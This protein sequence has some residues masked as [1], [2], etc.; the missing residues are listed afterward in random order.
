MPASIAAGSQ[1]DAVAG[2]AAARIAR[3]VADLVT[4]GSIDLTAKAAGQAHLIAALLPSGT[5]VYVNHLRRQTLADTAAACASLHEAGLEPVPHLAARRVVSR[6]EL[7]AF[8]VDIVGR[9]GVQKVLLVGGDERQAQGPY[10][11]ST[12][13]LRDGILAACGI[14]E[15]GFAGYPE[16]HPDIAQRVL[17]DATSERIEIAGSQELG[18]HIVTQ[19]SLAPTRVVEYCAALSRRVTG[20]PNYA[21]VAG[22]TDP[23]ALL[24]YAQLC[25]VSSSLRALRAQG[26]NA[27]G[28]VTHPDPGEQLAA[29]AHYCDAHDW[30]NVVGAHVYSFGGVKRTAAWMNEM[31]AVQTATR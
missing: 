12:H 30:C 1:H 23:L 5:K 24:K 15:V 8:L 17:E 29:I 14:R 6:G 11:D 10:A 20:V 21:G 16:G 22:P 27:A 2:A 25:G 26:I 7:E 4:C 18:V 9:A 3:A 19:F 28:L 31:I 13:L